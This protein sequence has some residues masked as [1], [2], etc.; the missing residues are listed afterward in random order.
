MGSSGW[1]AGVDGGPLLTGLRNSGMGSATTSFGFAAFG[2]TEAFLSW[3][4]EHGSEQK[5]ISLRVHK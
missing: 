5:H 2:A 1:G 4:R 3:G